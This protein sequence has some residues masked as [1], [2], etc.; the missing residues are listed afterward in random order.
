MSMKRIR[1]ARIYRRY[2][3]IAGL[4]LELINSVIWY[5]G[6]ETVAAMLAVLLIVVGVWGEVFFG[7][8]ARSAGDA[9]LAQYEARTAEANARAAEAQRQGIEAR[10]ELARVRT[11]RAILFT[12]GPTAAFISNAARQFPG[13]NF[14]TG[15]DL[16]SGEQADFAWHLQSALTDGGWLHI[17]VLFI[18]Q[19][20]ARPISGSVGATNVEIHLHPQSRDA[21]LPAATALIEVLNKMGIAATDAGFNAHSENASAI[22]ILIGAKQ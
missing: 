6:V 8:K 5:H 20:N 15:F 21:L 10:L 1:S 4:I 12:E 7:N 17:P 13:T 3:L 18:T 19:G 16:N 22:H 9:Q 2:V 14:D 11:P